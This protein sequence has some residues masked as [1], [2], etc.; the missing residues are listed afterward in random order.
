MSTAIG[1]VGQL[2]TIIRAQLAGKVAP[3]PKPG[4]REPGA[5]KVGSAPARQAERDVGALIELRIRQ[6]GRDD[7]QRGRKAVR[8]FLEAVLL[9]HLGEQMINDPQ[10]YQLLDDTQAAMESEPSCAALIA[11]AIEQLLSDKS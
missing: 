8:V 11:S 3:Q 1:G 6:I 9:S 5:G 10:F 7:P 2:V 4:Q